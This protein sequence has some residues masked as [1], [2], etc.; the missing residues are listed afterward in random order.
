MD[1][2]ELL[3]EIVFSR[4]ILAEVAEVADPIDTFPKSF[5][6][7]PMALELNLA[8]CNAYKTSG[9]VSLALSE[10]A[11]STVSEVLLAMAVTVRV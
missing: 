8:V 1:V 2:V 7:R 11:V 4:D 9:V 6:T 3:A 10:K 5:N